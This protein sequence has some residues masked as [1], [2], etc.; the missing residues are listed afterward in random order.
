MGDKLSKPAQGG[1]GT[2]SGPGGGMLSLVCVG[3]RPAF[4]L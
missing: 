2:G 4:N 1:S 3:L